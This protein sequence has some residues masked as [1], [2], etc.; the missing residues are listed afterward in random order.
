MNR[1]IADLDRA[2]FWTL[3]IACFAAAAAGL[4]AR[5]VDR[6]AETYREERSNY[7]IVRVVAPEEP[8]AIQSAQAVLASAPQ[9][10]RAAPITAARAAELLQQWGGDQVAIM[11]RPPLRL[12]EI[13]LVPGSEDTDVNGDLVAA[14]AQ[15]GVTGEVVRPQTGAGVAGM[16]MRARLIAILGASA[17]A[18]VMAL[19][20]SLAMRTMAARRTD[21]VVVLADLGATRSQA[22]GRVADEAASLGLRAGLLGAAL[23]AIVAVGVVLALVPGATID[24]LPDIIGFADAAPL[25]AAPLIAAFAAALGARAAASNIYN[26]AAKLR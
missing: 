12:I 4:F 7:A 13:E 5:G 23:A 20:V 3:A 18:A 10:A 2:L 16:A 8:S 25:A 9:V 1:S 17:F 15:V 22:A 11:E 21:F 26:R 24:T 19:V 6:L 14:L